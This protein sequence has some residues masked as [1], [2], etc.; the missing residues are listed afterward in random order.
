MT[1]VSHGDP[2]ASCALGGLSGDHANTGT[3]LEPSF[4]IDPAHPNRVRAMCRALRASR[5]GPAAVGDCG[6]SG[7]R[8]TRTPSRASSSGAPGRSVI[9]CPAA[10]NDAARAGTCRPSHPRGYAVWNLEYRR[11]GGPGRLSRLAHPVQRSQHCRA[12][13]GCTG[14]VGDR[15]GQPDRVPGDDRQP[16]CRLLGDG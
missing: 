15:R 9:S 11:T 7:A 12:V 5:P 6:S 4:A 14:L 3:A 1:Q 2:Y 8:T 10:A 16:G 13:G